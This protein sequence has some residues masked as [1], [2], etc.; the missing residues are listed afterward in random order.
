MVENAACYMAYYHEKAKELLEVTGVKL[1]F[2]F[3]LDEALMVGIE[4][5]LLEERLV[6]DY[7]SFLSNT[8]QWQLDRGFELPKS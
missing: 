6:K 4:T 7:R 5:G 2:L 1:H 8:Q 3:T